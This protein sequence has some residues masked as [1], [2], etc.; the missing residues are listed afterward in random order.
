MVLFSI[1]G[2][3]LKKVNHVDFKLERDIQ[4]IIEQNLRNIFGLDFVKSEFHLND[5]R[6]DTLAFDEETKSFVIIE[7]KKS[8][9]FS[10][11]D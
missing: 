10:V 9:N 8:S 11:I 4:N 6:M 7:Y 2:E 1:E 3:E 5:L